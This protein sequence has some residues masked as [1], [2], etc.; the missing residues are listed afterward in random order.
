MSES[1]PS[2][3]IPL[4]A[5]DAYLAG[6]LTPAGLDLADQ[7]TQEA[8]AALRQEN[9]QLTAVLFR[10]H[11]PDPGRLLNYQWGLAGVEE[12]QVITNH[13]LRCPHCAADALQLGPEAVD[14]PAAG[15]LAQLLE[16][17]R[18]R[19]KRF[20]ARPLP[21]HLAPVPLRH[22]LAHKQESHQPG[23]GVFVDS[24]THAFAVVE[25]EDAAIILTQWHNADGRCTVQGQLLGI[26]PEQAAVLGDEGLLATTPIGEAGIFQFSDLP[27]RRLVTF[28]FSSP[29]LEIYVPLYHP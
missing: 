4:W 17:W 21:P 12:R 16:D 19:F 14:R 5:L 13:L 27:S 25:L 28:C 26:E 23:E 1:S 9:E 2:H 8:L 29:T 15:G 7:A 22:A 6:V 24:R 20:I 10:L 3:P 18:A 11:C